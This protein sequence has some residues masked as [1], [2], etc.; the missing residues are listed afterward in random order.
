MIV[1]YRNAKKR[2]DKPIISAFSKI[3]SAVLFCTTFIAMV[4]VQIFFENLIPNQRFG[5][6]TTFKMLFR[7]TLIII[8]TKKG[9]V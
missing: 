6:E 8:I 2:F 7:L 9:D 5:V 1:V 4:K 3:K